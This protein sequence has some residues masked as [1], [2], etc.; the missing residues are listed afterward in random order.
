MHG[1]CGLQV[2][3]QAAT[4]ASSDCKWH[5]NLVS[6]FLYSPHCN[7]CKMLRD[8]IKK[9]NNKWN[10]KDCM[11]H[12]LR[13]FRC[14]KMQAH[15]CSQTLLQNCA[16]IFLSCNICFF[17]FLW[18]KVFLSYFSGKGAL[19]SASG[20]WKQSEVSG[21]LWSAHTTTQHWEAREHRLLT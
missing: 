6:F 14:L 11:W 15:V 10:K 18:P 7:L 1:L 17:H 20:H 2:L 8:S 16:Y 19:I 9:N 13:K 3:S 21:S 4:S 12:Y 5:C